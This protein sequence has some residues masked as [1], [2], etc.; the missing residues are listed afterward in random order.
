MLIVVPPSAEPLLSPR[1]AK[2]ILGEL[3]FLGLVDGECLA[4]AAKDGDCPGTGVG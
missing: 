4:T 3:D 2:D 1:A